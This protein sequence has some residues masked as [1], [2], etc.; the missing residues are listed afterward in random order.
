MDILTEQGPDYD[1]C[2]SRIKEKYGPNIHI[3]RQKKIRMG[4]F[5]GFFEKEGV[6]LSFMLT[7]D[8]SRL[9]SSGYGAR[10]VDFD[11]ERKKI[12]RQAAQTSPELAT[13]VAPH[14]AALAARTAESASTAMKSSS[15]SSSG[16][17]E[18]DSLETILKVV[19]KLES[20]LD[21]EEEGASRSEEHESISRIEKLLEQNDFSASFIRTMIGRLKKQFSLEELDSFD[22]VQDAVVSWIG[23]SVPIADL[24]HHDKPRI[25]VLVGPT[26]VGKTTTVAKL[27][28]AYSLAPVKSARPLNVR[29]ITIDN[30]RIGAKQQIEIYGNLM[31]I[32]VSFAESARDLQDLMVLHQDADVILIDTIGKSPKDYGK[33]AEM[34]HILEAAGTISE[35]HLTMSA[36]TKASDMREIMQQYET[37][38]V[39]SLIIT[40]FDETAHVG[41]ILSVV[42]ERG[43]PVAYV[44]TGQRVPQDF[45]QASVVRFL[46]NLDGFRI[47]RSKI[48]ELFP[49]PE[50]RF[51]WRQ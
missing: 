37:F 14:M 35:M 13:R 28:A 49:L 51:E 45:E 33:I 22:S 1:E 24:A 7:R 38:G 8:P 17:T 2:L 19:R 44:T 25:I 30:Y 42:Q 39:T 18:P 6:E 32:P 12:I 34:R 11:E 47:N 40:K 23:E 9:M 50:N 29:V 3:L 20:R 27:A 46:T 10:P 41:N 21:K 48:E 31:N 15:S 36:T 4:G 16:R 5:L 43:K 26:G